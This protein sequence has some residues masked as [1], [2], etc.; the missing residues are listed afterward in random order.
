MPCDYE[1]FERLKKFSDSIGA[2][3]G[4]EDFA[5]YLYSIVKMTKPRTVLELGTGLGTAALWIAQA[6]EE[7]NYGS[8]YTIDNG[9]EWE[10]L[11]PAVTQLV[12]YYKEEYND[13]IT[14]LFHSFK[15][16]GIVKYVNH[17]IENLNFSDEYDIVFSDFSHSPYYIFK[18]LAEIIPLMSNNSYIFI[19]SASTYYSSYHT[20][21]SI[22]DSFNIGK[23]P[24]TLLEL[25]HPEQREIFS[26]R[27]RNLKFE[28]THVI[29]NK[30]RDQNST[31]QIK[32]LPFDVMPQPRNNIR[33]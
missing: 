33:F 5:I 3:Y 20:L 32:I 21:E 26:N 2:V 27:V 31:A 23:I 13:Y 30:N 8:L 16:Q 28:L 22:I 1:K 15:Y 18:F 4:T 9:N 11:K 25:V 24:Y 6:L 12:K 17:D 29:E 10:R 19:D 7:N 14:N